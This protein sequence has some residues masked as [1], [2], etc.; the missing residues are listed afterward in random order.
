MLI[1]YWF[2]IYRASIAYGM[3]KFE[4]GGKRDVEEEETVGEWRETE[5][6]SISEILPSR[7][8]APQ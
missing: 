1:I 8:T 2:D 4:E 5:R 7:P 6:A 3:E